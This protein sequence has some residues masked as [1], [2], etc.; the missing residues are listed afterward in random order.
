MARSV[1]QE[2][3]LGVL[4]VFAPAATALVVARSP[5]G[6]E[7]VKKMLV[8]GIL[9][10]S[11]DELIKFIVLYAAIGAL[12]CLIRRRLLM[13][14]DETPKSGTRT[15]VWVLFFFPSFGLLRTS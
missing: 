1:R 10:V 2:A 13:S 6:A 3:V 15:P 5:Q 14:A 7:H 11:A 8:G 9:S 12:H 4:Y